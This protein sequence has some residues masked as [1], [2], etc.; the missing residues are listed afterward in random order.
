MGIRSDYT[1]IMSK[2]DLKSLLNNSNL[3]FFVIASFTLST[4]EIA[5]NAQ[6]RSLP[7]AG[8]SNYSGGALPNAGGVSL[9]QGAD[10]PRGAPAEVYNPGEPSLGHKLVHWEA[11]YMPL[12]IWISPGKKLVE[13]P[14]SQI[15]AQRPQEVLALLKADPT[16]SSLG[17]CT[18]WSPAMNSAVKSG[19][20]QW[21]EFQNEGLFS[22]EFVEDPRQANIFVFWTDRFVG[23]E[24]AGGVSTAGNTVAVLY[25]INEVRSKEASYGGQLPGT[26]V[27]IELRANNETFDKLQARSAHEFGHALGIKEHSPFNQ[28]LMCVNGIAN[29]LSPSDKATVRWLYR[30]RPQY[31]MLPPVL[32][33]GQPMQQVQTAPVQDDYAS[34]RPSARYKVNK[35]STDNDETDSSAAYQE[36][37]AE[38][39]STSS[40]R[41]SSKSSRENSSYKRA[42]NTSTPEDTTEFL[43]T[44]EG[45][46]K[47]NG[48][49]KKNRETKKSEE[50]PKKRVYDSTPAYSNQPSD[51]AS[52][53]KSLDSPTKDRDKEKEDKKI[54]ERP[55]SRKNSR[56]ADTGSGSTQEANSATQEPKASEGY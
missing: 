49:E 26:P 44:L 33:A 38:R 45:S 35:S 56:D 54:K 27:I 37:N 47:L 20:E 28:D 4:A 52:F 31:V 55:K 19:I 11:K 32:P 18:E 2:T 6:S 34:I 39:Q 9:Q 48:A 22:F 10:R 21:R 15:N 43:R 14:I 29:S 12:R 40:G 53:L 16:F 25:D 50:M 30:Q 8:F 51:T 24:G 17:S 41:E 3:L 23:D 5:A 13:E 7:K 1:E 42:G 36:T 46:S